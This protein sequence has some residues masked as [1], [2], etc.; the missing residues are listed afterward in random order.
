MNVIVD[1]MLVTSYKTDFEC[2]FLSRKALLKH[3]DFVS[4]HVPETE[5]TKGMIE[6]QFLSMMKEDSVLINTSDYG[7]QN[8]Q[9]ILNKLETCP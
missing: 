1:K 8:D 9:A 6:L 5:S 7:L 2:D 4:M 3:S